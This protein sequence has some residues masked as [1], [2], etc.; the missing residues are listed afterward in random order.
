MDLFQYRDKTAKCAQKNSSHKKIKFQSIRNFRK[1][2]AQNH[3]FLCSKNEILKQLRSSANVIENR[4]FYNNYYEMVYYET[5]RRFYEKAPKSKSK[6]KSKS[7][8][9]N[10]LK[11]RV[12]EESRNAKSELRTKL[13]TVIGFTP[14]KTNK[15]TDIAD[16]QMKNYPISFI[17]KSTNCAKLFNFPCFKACCDPRQPSSSKHVHCVEHVT[18]TFPKNKIDVLDLPPAPV[19]PIS[20][21][22]IFNPAKY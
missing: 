3:N 20:E 6:V 14:T 21:W 5:K 11:F 2:L 9:E 15:V 10:S 7:I 8:T 19:T 17:I 12:I 18:Y 22:Y 16:W 4:N 13:K 1:K